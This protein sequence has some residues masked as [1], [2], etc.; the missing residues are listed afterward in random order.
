MV[1]DWCRGVAAFEG[2]RSF[3][4][5]LGAE[6]ALSGKC[7]SSA[8]GHKSVESCHLEEPWGL[9]GAPLQAR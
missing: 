7:W 6:E 9:W 4:A 8:L 1:M 5:A 2:P 3:W